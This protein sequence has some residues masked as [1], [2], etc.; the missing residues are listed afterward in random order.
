MWTSG[1]QLPGSPG[2]GLEAAAH[3]GTIGIFKIAQSPEIIKWR[4]TILMSL[5]NW[6]SENYRL[7]GLPGDRSRRHFHARK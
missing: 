3:T 5:A 6:R 1:P 7:K 2:S 4:F